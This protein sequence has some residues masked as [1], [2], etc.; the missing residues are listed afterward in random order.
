MGVDHSEKDLKKYP[1]PFFVGESEKRMLDAGKLEEVVWMGL[2]LKVTRETL[3]AA[4]NEVEML[5]DWL[6]ERLFDVKY[7]N[8]ETEDFD[9]V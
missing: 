6:E 4:I 3:F 2:S 1:S 5:G 8:R 9:A 7:P